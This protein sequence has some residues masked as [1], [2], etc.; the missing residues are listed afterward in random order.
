MLGQIVYE[1]NASGDVFEYDF[2]GHG[3]GLYLIRIETANGLAVKKVSV[4]R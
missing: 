2:G 1:G 3:A 4:A